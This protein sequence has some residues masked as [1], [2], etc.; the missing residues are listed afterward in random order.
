LGL[1]LDVYAFDKYGIFTAEAKDFAGKPFQEFS[2]NIV[3]YLYDISNLEKEEIL[4]IKEYR[5]KS[6]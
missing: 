4:P 2:D 6:D 3:K 1:P 5:D